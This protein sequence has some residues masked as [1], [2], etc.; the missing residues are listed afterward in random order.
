MKFPKLPK[1]LTLNKKHLLMVAGLAV[2]GAMT[3]SS[4]SAK[5]VIIDV[6]T[7]EEFQVSHPIGAVN[8]PHNEVADKVASLGVSNADTIK[9]YSRG[10]NRAEVAKKALQSAG[11]SN[12]TVET[13]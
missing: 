3:L 9:V 6:R 4:A 5:T 7:P 2:I 10:G 12:V 11:Y 8:I 13:K 1:N